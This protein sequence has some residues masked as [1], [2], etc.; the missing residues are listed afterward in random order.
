VAAL[1]LYTL[2][3]QIVILRIY[4]KSVASSATPFAP[5]WAI[6]LGCTAA[7]LLTST[8]LPG[9]GRAI[10]ATGLGVILVTSP[11]LSPHPA[12]PRP[13]PERTYVR[14]LTEAADA[15]RSVVPAGAQAFVFGNPLP[16]YLGGAELYLR[17]ASH[18]TTLVPSPDRRAVQRSGLWGAEDLEQWLGRDARYAVVEPAVVAH[19]GA[20]PAYTPLMNR[21]QAL[22]DERFQPVLE[23]GGMAGTPRQRVYVRR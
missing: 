19:L 21:L 16:A 12:V 8:A 22:L 18:Q 17:Q 3:W 11:T 7:G 20:V 4:V 5:L 2:A 23:I 1:A 6:V 15:I 14:S 10:L 13:L 9:W